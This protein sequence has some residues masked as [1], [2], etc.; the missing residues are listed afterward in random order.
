MDH[1]PYTIIAVCVSRGY[2]QAI[3]KG[4]LPT[5]TVVHV[6][7]GQLNK[8]RG[9]KLSIDLNPLFPVNRFPPCGGK[10]IVQ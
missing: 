6:G 8:F 3:K 10:R 2:C 7:S 1:G 5:R 4:P 9:A